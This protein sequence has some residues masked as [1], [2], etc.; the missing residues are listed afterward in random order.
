M[1]NKK[2]LE[3]DGKR[4]Y[5]IGISL[6]TNVTNQ[7]E[8]D[9]ALSDP[10]IRIINIKGSD[11]GLVSVNGSHSHF[12]QH[13][14][15]FSGQVVLINSKYTV[16]VF[17]QSAVSQFDSGFVYYYDN[18]VGNVN[19]N[20]SACFHDNATGI[21]TDSQGWFF[22][23]SSGESYYSVSK[24][25]NY[26]KCKAADKSRIVV[27]DNATISKAE[28]SL[29]TA[30]D[31]ANV[32]NISDSE[33]V[34]SGDM[35]ALNTPVCVVLNNNKI[36]C[37][38]QNNL[39]VLGEKNIVAFNNYKDNDHYDYWKF[40]DNNIVKADFNKLTLLSEGIH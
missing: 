6:G 9:S 22:D 39:L 4:T 8:L 33:L 40:S 29:V 10:S 24:F 30:A 20:S 31:R 7:T 12:N 34:L 11:S 25:Y 38:K 28:H 27:K 5:D 37:T 15:V 21:L 14:N 19:E 36:F 16:Y 26:S 13:I 1:V 23:H 18:T 32:Y 35:A 3:N 17:G 2:R